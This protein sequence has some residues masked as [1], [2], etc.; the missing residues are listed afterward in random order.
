MFRK[1][2][3]ARRTVDL[4]ASFQSGAITNLALD[5]I[6]FSNPFPATLPITGTFSVIN[7]G[8]SGTSN[9]GSL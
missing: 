5:G 8:N 1:P 3:V 6:T 4:G 2:V 9:N 7:S